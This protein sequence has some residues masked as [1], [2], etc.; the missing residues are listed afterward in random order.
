MNKPDWSTAPDWAKFLAQDFDESWYWYDIEPSLNKSDK[1]RNWVPAPG[2][3]CQMATVPSTTNWLRSMETRPNKTQFGIHSWDEAP[4]WAE[5][6][7]M[8]SD[9]KWNWYENKPVIHDEGDCKRQWILSIDK[10]HFAPL[11]NIEFD[12]DNRRLWKIT[13][14]SKP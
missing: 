7:A 11:E 6:I 13:L 12:P 5:W 1:L 10:G 8:D 3:I 9:G 4:T 14:A 2:G